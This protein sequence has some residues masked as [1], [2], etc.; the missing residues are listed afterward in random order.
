MYVKKQPTLF[1][2]SG[3]I[4]IL[5]QLRKTKKGANAL[6]ETDSYM[7]DMQIVQEWGL[8][9]ITQKSDT[10][11]AR[12]WTVSHDDKS[13]LTSSECCIDR[14]VSIFCRNQSLLDVSV[15]FPF[16]QLFINYIEVC[17]HG[18]NF[19]V[20]CGGTAWCETNAVIWSMQTW[21]YI[22]TESQSCF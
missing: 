17:W 3:I 4:H 18:R 15:A 8:H 22:N 13:W 6:V 16:C 14:S 9:G 12:W 10:F 1:Y 21:S 7:V 2:F 5:H 19:V 20:K 11:V